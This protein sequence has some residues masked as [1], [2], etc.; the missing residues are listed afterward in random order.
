[1][2]LTTLDAIQEKLDDALN[3]L[4]AVHGY[5]SLGQH[6]D[7]CL[8]RGIEELEKLERQL[9]RQ[10]GHLEDALYVSRKAR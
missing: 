5:G 8:R 10:R 1:M 2:R 7:T 4:T 3:A 9:L 6:E